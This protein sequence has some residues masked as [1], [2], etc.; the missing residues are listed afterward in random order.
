MPVSANFL[1]KKQ[2]ICLYILLGTHLPKGAFIFAAGGHTSH[3]S[4]TQELFAAILSLSRP[5]PGAPSQ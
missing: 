3:S 5:R 2:R 4:V 1:W